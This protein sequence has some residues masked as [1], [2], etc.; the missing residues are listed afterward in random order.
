MLEKHPASEVLAGLFGQMMGLI[1]GRF[2]NESLA[3]IHETGMTLP[4]LVALHILHHRGP[5][6]MG[7]LSTALSLSASTTSHL[8]DKL[9]EKGM[10]MRTEDPEDRRQKRIELSPYGF[11]LIDR[12]NA[13]RTEEFNLA[14]AS[15]DPQLQQT[16]VG[17]FEQVVGE[18]RR[19]HPLN[20]EAVCPPSSR[21]PV[22]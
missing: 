7:F 4:Q 8:V 20:Q 1:H 18:L 19:T 16:L 3:L 5:G 6:S 14:F 21:S 13:A 9:V 2:A 17:V 15:L 22:S 11:S 10:V 12:L